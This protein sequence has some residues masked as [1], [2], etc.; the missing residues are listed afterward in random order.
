M[1]KSIQVFNFH[2]VDRCLWH[3][4]L[5]EVLADW[6]EYTAFILE[7]LDV[8]DMQQI[9][10]WAREIVDE[11]RPDTMLWRN[12]DAWVAETAEARRWA[13]YWK[14]QYRSLRAL[15]IKEAIE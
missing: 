6:S 3:A 4:W 10:E 2:G 12:R 15:F 13:R 8:L 14:R 7:D 1:S 5:T 9:Q 11:Y